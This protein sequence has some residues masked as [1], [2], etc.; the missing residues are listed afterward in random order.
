MA[1][2]G[3]VIVFCLISLIGAQS[4]VPTIFLQSTTWNQTTT[5]GGIINC[6][7]DRNVLNIKCIDRNLIQ[8]L[9]VIAVSCLWILYLIYFNSRLVGLILTLIV[10]QFYKG[11]KTFT[12]II[13]FSCSNN[14]LHFRCTHQNWIILIFCFIWK[15]HVSRCA[16]HHTGSISS[17]IQR[18]L[19]LSMVETL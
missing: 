12:L 16:I 11:N 14:P 18:L 5:P 1:D 13:Y 17:Y 15:N 8:L 2:L 3:S 10:N 9:F 4:T 6:S 7:D 19:Y